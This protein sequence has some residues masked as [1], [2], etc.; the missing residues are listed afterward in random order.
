MYSITSTKTHSDVTTSEVD[1]MTWNIENWIS[2]KT[3]HAYSMK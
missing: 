2:Q 1:G 3:G